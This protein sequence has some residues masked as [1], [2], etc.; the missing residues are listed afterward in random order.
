MFPG[1]IYSNF[2]L[3]LHITAY[4]MERNRRFLSV[5]RCAVSRETADFVCQP[6][7]QSYFRHCRGVRGNRRKMRDYEREKRGIL[8]KKYHKNGQLETLICNC[9]GK[10]LAV[11]HGILREGAIS[12]DYTWD[13]F[14]E[15]DG[16]IHRFDLCEECYDEL[17][18][19]YKIPV[20][21]KEQTEY[22]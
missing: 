5:L 22:L 17:I 12:V 16:Q 18:G 13:Y 21:I 2:H 20:D 11:D 19:G 6:D 8:M 3:K 14:S 1:E 15:K 4:I 10:K 7:V 9:C